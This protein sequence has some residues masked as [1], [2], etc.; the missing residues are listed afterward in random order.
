V[1][2]HDIRAR[3]QVVEVHGLLH[4]RRQRPGVL[5]GDRR[6]VPEHVHAELQRSVRDLDADGA[7]PHDAERALRQLEADELLLAGFDGFVELV[8]ST[9][10]RANVVERL[11]QISCRHEQ[12]GDDELFHCVG[13]CTRRVE[14][15][16]AELAEL[17]DGNIVGARPCAP[18]GEQGLRQRHVVHLERPQQ[19]G[20]RLAKLGGHFIAIARQ[21]I[22][23]RDGDAIQGAHFE[24]RHRAHP[25]RFAKSAMNA[26][27]AST[28]ASGI[29]L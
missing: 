12:T 22:E 10:Q 17:R 28:P 7:E 2:G 18:D 3:E 27:K 1:H 23:P 25:C 8:A 6:V 11:R 14:N 15:R 24:G 16:H 29:A 20:V 9:L 5:D 26:T 13:V 19:N 21:A 4:A